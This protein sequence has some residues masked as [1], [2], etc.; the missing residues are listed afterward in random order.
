VYLDRREVFE[1]V[2][3]RGGFRDGLVKPEEQFIVF[4]HDVA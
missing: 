3:C 2:R 4:W 1:A